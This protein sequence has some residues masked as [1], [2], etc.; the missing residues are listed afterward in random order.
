MIELKSSDGWLLTAIAVGT[1]GDHASLK[2]IIAA[3]DWMNHAIFTDSELNGG[4]SRLSRSGLIEINQGTYKLTDC[5]KSIVEP[6]IKKRGGY[7]LMKAVSDKI[8][9][10]KW[11]PNDDPNKM[12]DPESN[13]VYV[14]HEQVQEAFEE[15]T[16]ALKKK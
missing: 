7:P 11:K 15:Y 2:N 16:K 4:F 9:A 14:T 12:N 8:K 5:A 6:E 13:I 10:K 1:E 3:G